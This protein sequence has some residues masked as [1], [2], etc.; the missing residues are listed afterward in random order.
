[1]SSQSGAS[2]AQ[3]TELFEKIQKMM[4]AKKRPVEVQQRMYT[5][6]RR[7]ASMMEKRRWQGGREEIE[8]TVMYDVYD[9]RPRQTTQVASA[10]P[11]MPRG[12]FL[13]SDL[14][15]VAQPSSRPTTEMKYVLC[16]SLQ[17]SQQAQL[18]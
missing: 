9:G 8:M 12:G 1:M 4:E 5:Q 3:V 16:V 6:L 14:S 17:D 13:Q 15:S 18:F 2:E 7:E 10:W 11:Y